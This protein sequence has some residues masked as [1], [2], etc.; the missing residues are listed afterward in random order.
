MNSILKNPKFLNLSLI[1]LA[2]SVVGLAAC[3]KDDQKSITASSAQVD[4]KS[5]TPSDD[6]LLDPGMRE[7]DY[8]IAIEIDAPKASEISKFI[9]NEEANSNIPANLSAFRNGLASEESVSNFGYKKIASLRSDLVIIHD[10][11]AKRLESINFTGLRL[12]AESFDETDTQMADSIRDLTV[13]AIKQYSQEDRFHWELFKTAYLRGR[14][15]II[16][17]GN[18]LSRLEAANAAYDA[19]T[20]FFEDFKSI[21]PDK[22]LSVLSKDEIKDLF[23][24]YLDYFTPATEM[25]T[26]A[27][28]K[29]QTEAS[30]KRNPVPALRSNRTIV[31]PLKTNMPSILSEEQIEAL[32][33]RLY[34]ESIN[35]NQF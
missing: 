23:E 35:L 29:A 14:L 30:I 15:H 26:P 10:E 11:K 17:G 16:D 18:G 21:Y 28:K 7:E 27:E 8:P 34:D 25:M 22:E 4:Q 24:N 3:N 1:L 13:R 32:N 6:P 9:R 12:K 2:G 5:P 33:K 19:E 31:L 20:S